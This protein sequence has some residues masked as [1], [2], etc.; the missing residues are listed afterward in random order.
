MI[1]RVGGA[2]CLWFEKWVGLTC[3]DERVGGASLPSCMELEGTLVFCVK[4]L[5]DNPKTEYDAVTGHFSYKVLYST[6]RCACGLWC[7]WQ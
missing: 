6:V 2:N 3:S 4:A 1:R 7:G 5:I